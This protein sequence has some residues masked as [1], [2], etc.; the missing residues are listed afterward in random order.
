M[1][2]G[3][4]GA[5]GTV[6]GSGVR[7]LVRESRDPMSFAVNREVFVS[8]GVL[9]REQLAIFDRCW[10]YVGHASELRAPGDFKTRW[11]AGR[12]VIFC[13]D[14]DGR[15]RCLINSCRHRGSLVCR[16]REGNA[17]NFYCMYHGWAVRGPRITWVGAPRADAPRADRP[18]RPIVP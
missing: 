1:A 18:R 13:R 8:S 16:E 3:G 11:V 12:P 2:Q 14:R 5:D 17:R 7:P 9:E 15:V 4:N 6:D 10:I